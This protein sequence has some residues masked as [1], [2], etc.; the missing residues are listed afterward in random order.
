MPNE[1]QR[2]SSPPNRSDWLKRMQ[3]NSDSYPASD[4]LRDAYEEAKSSQSALLLA[5]RRL[6]PHIR[7]IDLPEE[8]PSAVTSPRAS[9]LAGPQQKPQMALASSTARVIDLEKSAAE[10]EEQRLNEDATTLCER[11]GIDP[12]LPMRRGVLTAELAAAARALG[13]CEIQFSSRLQNIDR[14][15]KD[16]RRGPGKYVPF[17]V[18]KYVLSGQYIRK[19]AAA[20][21]TVR[22]SP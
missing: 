7:P 1:Q 19:G 10:R 13:Y 5:L 9:N 15:C 14:S 4:Y 8:G 2:L 18:A 6:D 20:K 11:A 16:A 22:S 21:N 17:D 12:H 3:K